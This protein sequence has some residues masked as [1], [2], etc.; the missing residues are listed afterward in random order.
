MEFS[1]EQQEHIN[2]LIG[3]ARVKARQQAQA[4]LEEKQQ[5]ARKQALKDGEK[6]K[7]LAEQHEQ[8]I[9]ELEPMAERVE[10]FNEVMQKQLVSLYETLGERAKKAVEVFSDPLTKLQ[11]LNENK[12]LFK[13]NGGAQ[14]TPRLPKKTADQERPQTNRNIL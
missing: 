14:G 13:P 8:R 10:K 1:E 4:E 6:W 11:W 7:D 5:E 2:H 3:Q 9:A 12:D